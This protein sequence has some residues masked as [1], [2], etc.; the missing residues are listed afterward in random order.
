MVS[1]L[2]VQK[3]AGPYFDISTM[4]DIRFVLLATGSAFVALGEF[5]IIY[6]QTIPLVPIISPSR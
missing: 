1:S 2:F 6:N 5:V 3:K 4:T